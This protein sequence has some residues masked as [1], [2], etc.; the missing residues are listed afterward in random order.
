MPIFA[1]SAY[2]H[3]PTGDFEPHPDLKEGG[4]TAYS[5]SV[6]RERPVAQRLV[7]AL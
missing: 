7:R 3:T 1:K 4:Y 2:P 5:L 6:W